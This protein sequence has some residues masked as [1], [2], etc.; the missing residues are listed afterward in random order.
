ML[1]GLTGP[2]GVTVLAD[3]KGCFYRIDRD[4]LQV[5]TEPRNRWAR[6]G[7]MRVVRELLTLRALAQPAMID[8]HAAAF[9]LDG[10]AVLIAGAKNAGKTT[11][12][13]HAL[14]SGRAGL[15]ANDRVLVNR[16]SGQ[17]LGV[18][19]VVRLRETTE[20][21]FPR[22]AGGMPGRAALRH[23]G[24]LASGEA[25]EEAF[26]TRSPAQLAERTGTTMIPQAPLGAIVFPRISAEV[27]GWVLEPMAP[28]D[29]AARLRESRYGVRSG[30][31]QRTL[32][33]QIAGSPSEENAGDIERVAASVPV[34]EC[35][36]GPDA[37]RNGAETWLRAL[38]LGEG[39]RT[40]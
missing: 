40:R 31:V 32:L 29:A 35:R 10:R 14:V 9:V 13:V 39:Y 26:L 21:F 1:A 15:L 27:S 8:L 6:L 2:G 30:P 25:S 18:P 23:A 3:E 37:Y 36:L 24:E 33:H 28:A 22:L 20:R 34:L 4:R 38:P 5:I 16:G 19:T 11:L 12:L 7:L 17:V